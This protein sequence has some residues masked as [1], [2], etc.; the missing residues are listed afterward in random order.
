MTTKSILQQYYVH[1]FI[2]WNQEKVLKLNPDFQRRDVWTP[3][4]KVFLIDTILREMPIPKIF[5]RTTIDS[6]TKKSM[7]EVVDG[8]QRLRA[9]LDF[10]NDKFPL[11]SR[12]GEYGGKRYSELPEEA[13]DIFLT[14]P[15]AV[16]Q[17]VNAS[18]TDVLEV[19]A[20][21]NSYNVSLNPAE[22]RHAKYQGEFKWEVHQASL[23]WKVL[24][25]DL[26]L[27]SSRDRLRMGDDTLIA[28]MYQILISGVN[29]GGAEKI[30]KL[31]SKYDETF[32]DKERYRRSLDECLRFLLDNFSDLISGTELRRGT[33][34]LMLFAAVASQ[35]IGIPPGQLGA[36]IPTSG[37]AEVDSIRTRLTEVAAALED[38]SAR[39]RYSAL[40]AASK[41][42][43]QRI[44]TR[45][46]RFAAYL[47]VVTPTD[48]PALH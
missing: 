20:R 18:D 29:D 44:A 35:L 9:I 25:E 12:A 17:L 23:D 21:L 30:D 47:E 36:D 27:V 37:L 34:F 7:R 26:G 11:T 33:Q 4:A 38:E 2:N 42:S 19:F 6:R 3:Q 31:Y 46:V 28:E 5:I 14:Y 24:W 10:S 16:D 13:K 39:G 48:G 41:G 22:K 40:V 43:T 45:R 1:D 8:Q 32:N 15:L